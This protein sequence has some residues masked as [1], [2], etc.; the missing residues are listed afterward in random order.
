MTLTDKIVKNIS[1]ELPVEYENKII[2]GDSKIELAKLL[3]YT[4]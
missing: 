1:I 3:F 4:K 2:C